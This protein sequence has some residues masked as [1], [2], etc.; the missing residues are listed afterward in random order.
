MKYNEYIEEVSAMTSTTHGRCFRLGYLGLWL[1]AFVIC[2]L[3]AIAFA[4]HANAQTQAVSDTTDDYTPLLDRKEAPYVDPNSPATKSAETVTNPTLDI[5]TLDPSGFPH[6]CSYITILGGTGDPLGGQNH[7]SICVWQD[8]TKI[9][10]FTVV[11][12]LKDSCYTSIC[13]VIDRSGSMAD[14]NKIT[15]AKNA[16]KKIVREMAAFDRIAIVSFSNCWTLDQNFTSDTTLLINAINGFVANGRTA[17]FDGIWKGVDITRLEAGSKAVIALTDGMENNSGSCAGGPNGL[18]DGF[19]NDSTMI[20]SLAKASSIP[21][22]TIS[23][24]G[25]F[26][27]QYLQALSKGA[28]GGYFNAPTGAQLDS[29]YNVIKT[30]LC[31]RYI[32][33]YQSPDTIRSGD[34]HNVIV[35]KKKSTG[36]CK[37]CDTAQYC[38]PYPPVI[39]ITVD[40]TCRRWNTP[41]QICATITDTDTPPASLI[42]NLFYTINGGPVQQTSMT[43]TNST[44]CY[45]WSAANFPCTDNGAEI[46]FYITA[47]DGTSTVASPSNAPTTR[48]HI[49]ICPNHPP[50]CNLSQP[51]PPVCTPPVDFVAFSPTDID[52]NFK[53]C[54]LYGDGSLV[55]GGW[56]NTNPIPGTT[57]NARIVC[58]DSCGDSCYFNLSRT[59]PIRQPIQCN[60]PDG[61]DT[62][63]H[64]CQPAKI[65]LPVTGGEGSSCEIKSGP[66]TLV[67]G[68][69]SYNATVDAN[70]TF[71]IQCIGLC[72]SCQSTYT[73]HILVDKPPVIHCPQDLT[74]ECDSIGAFGTPTVD[75]EAPATVKIIVAQ[76]D[77]IPGN[78][79]DSYQLKLTY[80]ATDT[81]G[82]ADTCT[83]TISIVDHKKPVIHCP[84]PT[85]VSCDNIPTFFPPPVATDNCDDTVTVTKVGDPEKVP[86]PSC[87][88]QY[89]IL[90]RWAAEDDCGNADT[91]LQIIHVVDTTKP[92][93]VGCVTE[94]VY[95]CEE[96]FNKNPQT[97]V[98][99]PILPT[100]HDNCDPN[101]KVNFSQIGTEG[102]MP[103]N[104]TIK[105]AI[106]ATDGC[107]NVSDT[108]YQNLKIVDTIPPVILCPT[109]GRVA[110]DQIPEEFPAPEAHDN[111]SQ[112]LVSLLSRDSL[113]GPCAGNY[114]IRLTWVA[115]DNC[116]LKDTCQQLINVYDETKPYFVKCPLPSTVECDS[117]PETWSKPEGRDNCDP[118]PVVTMVNKVTVPGTQCP[119][120]YS[121]QIY[122]EVKDWCGNADTCVQTVHVE[123]TTAP[124]II[125]PAPLVFEC[126]SVPKIEDL[127]KPTVTDNC[128]ANPTL[129]PFAISATGP[130]CPQGYVLVI[131][132]VATDHCG[133]KDSCEQ[134]VTVVDTTAPVVTCPKD[135][136]LECDDQFPYPGGTK[137]IVPGTDI[138]TT[139]GEPWPF[140]VPS[141]HDN[142]DQ[143]PSLSGRFGAIL[144]QNPCH[145]VFQAIYSSADHCGN[146]D[147]CI[148]TITVVDSTAPRITCPKDTTLACDDQFPFPGGVKAITTGAPIK[149]NATVE[150][151]FGAPKATDNCDPQPGFDSRIGAIV[152]PNPCHFQF[153]VIYYAFDRCKNVDS[154]LQIVTVVDTTKPIL[155][156]EPARY[157]CDKLPAEF[158]KPK[159]TDNCDPNPVVTL[160]SPGAPI[161]GQCKNNYTIVLNWIA[162]DAC[163]NEGHCQQLVTIF[164]STPPVVTCPPDTTLSCDQAEVANVTKIVPKTPVT[165]G[166]VPIWPY[167]VPSAKDNCDDSV[168]IYGYYNR[169]IDNNPCHFQFEVGYIGTDNCFNADTC[170]QIVTI[171]DTTAPKITCPPDTTF[172]CDQLGTAGNIKSLTSGS[173]IG[174]KTGAAA[175]PYGIP[176]AT[177]NC[178]PQPSLDGYVGPILDPNPCHY[179][180]A[181]IYHAKDR[182]GNTDSCT[183]VLTIVDKTAPVLTC[184]PSR[185]ECDNVPKE[186]P[187]P[188]AQD[189][190][191]AKPVVTL[192]GVD[193]PVFDGCPQRY[194]LSLHWQAK[195]ACGNADTCVQTVYVSDTKRPIVACPPDTTIQCQ[196][197]KGGK[198]GEVIPPALWP[199]GD[200][201]AKDNCDPSP[202][203]H[204]F[205]AG[206]DG[207]LPCH[208]YLT[209]G[210][211]AVDSCGNVSDTC[212]QHVQVVDTTKPVVVCPKDT[213]LTC[214]DALGTAKLASIPVGGSIKGSDGQVWPYGTPTAT[215]NCD[216]EPFLG[217]FV[218]KILD[219]N[220]CHRQV[221][222]GYFAIDHCQNADTCFQIVTVVDTTA[223]HLEC[224]PPDT[225]QCNDLNKDALAARD[226]PNL[227]KNKLQPIFVLKDDCDPTPILS[228]D[229][230][231]FISGP[232]PT[233]VYGWYHATDHCGNRSPSCFWEFVI[234]DT[235]KPH[236]SCP[237]DTSVSCAD[238][239]NPQEAFAGNRFGWAK[240][241]DDCDET[242]R[243][244]YLGWHFQESDTCPR[245]AVRGWTAKDTCGNISDTCYQHITVFDNV[246]PTISCPGPLDFQCS[247]VDSSKFGWP[248]ANDN[249][250]GAHI[251][252]VVNQKITN[253]LCPGGYDLTRGWRAVD[254]C[255]NVSDTC[256]QRIHV[257]DT[258]KP[259][260]VCAKDETVDCSQIPNGKALKDARDFSD[261]KAAIGFNPIDT[262][263]DN[264]SPQVIPEF[265]ITANDTICPYFYRISVRV[266]DLCGNYSDSCVWTLHITDTTAP[267][268]TCPQ[269]IHAQC[270]N[271]GTPDWGT[272]T[273]Y[274]MCF[275]NK[276][277]ITLAKQD[278]ANRVGN[279]YYEVRR[280]FVAKDK[281]GNADTCI[282]KI[283]FG[284]STAPICHVP[285]DTVIRICEP[286]QVCLPV[287]ATD[288]CDTSVTCTVISGP[289]TI[290]GGK[291]CYNT[292]AKCKDAETGCPE[293]VTVKCTDD[294][295]NSCTS[296]FRV[297]IKVNSPPVIIGPRDTT[298][299]LCQPGSICTGPFSEFDLDRNEASYNVPTWASF[300]SPRICFTPDTT[301]VYK[302]WLCVT[303]SCGATTC[304]T[305]NVTVRLNRPPV[306]HV[307][308]DTTIF[309]CDPAQIS[310]PV[311][312]T[313]PDGGKAPVCTLV[314]KVVGSLNNGIWTYT[315][316]E[317]GKY[318]A[319]VRCTDSCGL[320]CEDEFCVTV[321]ITPPPICRQTNDTTIAMCHPQQV[322]LPVGEVSPV[323]S[324]GGS[325]AAMPS[326]GGKS[327][328]GRPYVQQPGGPNSPTKGFQA[329]CSVISGAGTVKEGYW[330][331]TPPAHDT[332]VNVTVQ[333]ADTCGHTCNNDFTVTFN[334]N[335]PPVCSLL[336]QLV[337]PICTPDTD[338]VPLSSTDPEGSIT[339][340]HLSG[341][342][343]LVPGGWKYPDPVPGSVVH[344]TVTCV[345][346]C[347][348]S[349]SIIFSRNY[350]SRIPVECHVP[351][352]TTVRLCEAT[353]IAMP[354]TGGEGSNCRV[355]DGPGTIDQGIWSYN[356]T[357]DTTFAV[358]VRCLSL[359]DSCQSTFH[360]TVDMNDPP[361]C[362]LPNDTTF[363]LCNHSDE[364][365][366]PVF[367]TDP[368]GNF[369]YCAIDNS[370]KG[371]SF[372]SLIDGKWCWAPEEEGTFEIPIV[373]YDSC[374]A[375]CRGSFH[376][377]VHYNSEPQCI[378]P[379]DTTIFLCQPTEVC[380]PYGAIDKDNNL[381]GCNFSTGSTK[382]VGNGFFWC[383]TPT[384]DTTITVNT[385]CEDS[386]GASCHSSFTVTFDVNQ[387]P[388][389]PTLADTSYFLCAPTQICRPFVAT[390]PDNNLTGCQ[391]V[392]GPGTV[393]QGQWCFTPT[394]SGVS[395][396]TIRC[397]DACGAFC[398]KS[399]QITVRINSQPT[400]ATPNDT[401]IF[402]CDPAQ[403]CLPYSG[404]DV[405]G[406]MFQCFVVDKEGKT[407]GG[408]WCRF[409][410]ASEKWS[411]TFHCEDSCGAFCE[412]VVSVN[413]VINQPPVCQYGQLAPP[414]CTPPVAF[415]PF[416]ST[417]P[418]GGPTTCKL[419]DGKGE[420]V[421][422]GW[423]YV[424]PIPGESFNV[425]II[426]TDTCGAKCKIDFTASFPAS[427]PPICNLPHDT[428][429]F[430]CVPTAVQ[431]PV[432]AAGA[433]CNKTAGPGT[434]S[435]G[436]WRYT[437]TAE[438]PVTVTI[439]CS[440]AC[441]YCEGTFTVNFKFNHPPVCQA[442]PDTTLR[443]CAGGTA[444]LP[445]YASDPDNNLVGSTEISGPGSITGSTWSFN[446]VIDNEYVVKFKTV[447]ACGLAD[448]CQF[449]V[450]ILMNKPP[451]LNVSVDTTVT[452]CTF[453]KFCMP[454]NISDRENNVTT[455]Q[456]TNGR[457]TI[458]QSGGIWYWCVT[459]SVNQKFSGKIR[460]TDACGLFSEK[461]F[462]VTINYIDQPQCNLP[463]S[464]S[465]TFCANPICIPIHGLNAP[466]LRGVSCSIVTGPGAING[467]NWCVSITGVSQT[468]N[469]TLRC[470]NTCGD[471][472]LLS[473]HYTFTVD[474]INCQKAGPAAIV[475]NN[476]EVVALGVAY[477]DVDGSGEINVTDLS[478]LMRLVQSITRSTGKNAGVSVTAASA[479]HYPAAADV[480]CDGYIN[481]ADVTALS[482]YLFNSGPAPCSGK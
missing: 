288:D 7:D 344:I 318:C 54:V 162:K 434:V 357:H 96:F 38:E 470:A 155:S 406:N 156:C 307:P 417:D 446:P 146:K 18:G 60:I 361:V 21:L 121:I 26:D 475:G 461:I 371:G 425:V 142:C 230:M 87:F 64:L 2:S 281:C 102:S 464:G 305:V 224:P 194:T 84:D 22:Y 31:T 176:S 338:F 315:P 57:A 303:D 145:F 35:C 273:A 103:C 199:Y 312:A 436:F 422:G 452:M 75:D 154:C 135:T 258:I 39:A 314:G 420:L 175:W 334:V 380:L 242:P 458:E 377:T 90:V 259:V 32:V 158:P 302:V 28:G 255:G 250:S 274:D 72:D 459:D 427:A 174:N 34:C 285:R 143:N 171:V 168:Q 216:P 123:D 339:N 382:T 15:A 212:M 313:D 375:T 457:G 405:D 209:V 129:Q 221:Q 410:G 187:V 177:D 323:S 453:G 332:V 120:N 381:K 37:Y 70:L 169:T 229:S 391:V 354:V 460:A 364:I 321:Y 234:E 215:D 403:V 91:C 317:S 41:V 241:F 447:D 115:T 404:T 188:V 118:K 110:C 133:N 108:C 128:D 408:N 178:D 412:R 12:T 400:C 319:T 73:V 112:P 409:I 456:V 144:D 341:P 151:P 430:Q 113:P 416:T 193:D 140:G 30:R 132:W 23:L 183:Q 136:T 153:Q 419:I 55:P 196:D 462:G 438:G 329:N 227:F 264:C 33:C 198:A 282:Q 218:G 77:S 299:T 308:N 104:F 8:G 479:G 36:E 14:Q 43:R 89:D 294:C 81:C 455:V 92:T 138:K 390:D 95:G 277:A 293:D 71:T 480:N 49:H 368:N 421:P 467:Q 204:G 164:D 119:Q 393:S 67:N 139:A 275:G 223:P 352:D 263:Y 451:V 63:F 165:K 44:W 232:C 107:G 29:I 98:L 124:H 359:C 24:G 433:V 333:C 279:C 66:G 233:I 157:E 337:D 478:Q 262:A 68:V 197:F 225:L 52:G 347:G 203:I 386:C 387:A 45:T 271:V 477:G 85:T 131:K 253:E 310:L 431:L 418:E 163:G 378:V 180:V 280:W 340:C 407:T 376:V 80:V 161:P 192:L 20:V 265:H 342:G 244:V 74:F 94:H 53:G 469:F 370:S 429:I 11:Q 345:D 284:D 449:H 245:I 471:T 392:S 222:I 105:Y 415:V 190:C 289:G 270:G 189:N 117:V 237:P 65:S 181:I 236:V 228:P 226:L 170:F 297:T 247:D 25:Q 298:Y 389:C 465:Y 396:V 320:Y 257:G 355:I 439:R 399:F 3:P 207:S 287:Y 383:Y 414:A 239:G 398:E 238:L 325:D 363:F 466:Q 220:P 147:S 272:P 202:E 316:T 286:G 443:V 385:T 206:V 148:Q 19:A 336:V 444:T 373:C 1:A 76:R 97:S 205:I 17:F 356:A 160:G 324:G 173:S 437:P 411:L 348:D 260:L 330:C 246:K 369:A 291:W 106:W 322:C 397:T 304:D 167:G 353:K 476:G 10:S 256:F 78:C 401:T 327:K 360:V 211:Y 4:P 450:I 290:S 217:G 346:T 252:L 296:T 16:A 350:P 195:D 426:C 384:H 261:I 83:Q 311:S 6:I 326:K 423:Q 254:G 101:P 367:A 200:P 235:T 40:T 283:I 335:E 472:C 395:N 441:D 358:T 59:Y 442:P 69:W 328:A 454:L 251:E 372:G 268:I 150:W 473:R 269:D 267:V 185:Y 79:A 365:C 445:I 248:T 210:Y 88:W 351:N 208:L 448:T 214:S 191:D 468:F 249:C 99:P 331:Y 440:N 374:G 278:T 51:S 428:T 114:Q 5:T 125:C 309:L 152:D 166:P 413:F 111:C 159:A 56:Q 213:T 100:A 306:C 201:G 240:A 130:D 231:Q 243:V 48:H 82:L 343:E 182:C 149:T 301:G 42:V 424:G 137:A 134:H 122:W 266:K 127:P 362:H 50:N 394:Q 86:S 379:H 474:P 58:T 349:C 219:D 47:S 481:Q 295:G 46:Q 109:E 186:W 93:L 179:Q 435:G 9:D 61:G 402:L 388:Q 300:K 463:T 482:E 27:P 172:S 276:V 13:L 292:E 366:R 116:G 184:E 141:T 126:D 432:S 62:T